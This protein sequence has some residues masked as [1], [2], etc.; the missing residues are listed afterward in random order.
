LHHVD[1]PALKVFVAC[2]E[3]S[4]VPHFGGAWQHSAAA[5][6]AIVRW[7]PSLSVPVVL[8]DVDAPLLTVFVAC[9]EQSNVLHFG[10]A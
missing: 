8:H 2:P 10:G 3:Q 9:P 4:N 5:H 7:M 1:A 6:L